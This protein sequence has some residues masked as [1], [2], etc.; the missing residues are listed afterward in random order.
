LRCP[1]CGND[2]PAT[3]RFCGM[4]GATLLQAEP[5]VKAE[6]PAVPARPFAVPSGQ[7]PPTPSAPAAI[8]PIATPSRAGAPFSEDVREPISSEVPAISGPS[9]LGLNDPPPAK[10]RRGSLS[11]DPGGAPGSRSLDYLLEDDDE[12]KSGGAWKFVLILIALAL[13]VGF[14]YLRW[15]NQAL[16]P[17]LGLSAHKP[18]ATPSSDATDSNSAAGTNAPSA[19][20]SSSA[21]ATSPTDAAGAPSA[22][23]TAPSSGSSSAASPSENPATTPAP[24]NSQSSAPSQPQGTNAAAAPAQANPTPANSTPAAGDAAD[25]GNASGTGAASNPA[26]AADTAQPDSAPAKP[27]PKPRPA[28]APVRVDQVAEARK[29]LYGQGAPQSCDRGLRLLKPLADQANPK[30][31]IE[32]GALYSAGLCTPRDLPTAYR[33]FALALRK[34][35]ANQPLQGDLQK[36]WGEMTQPE[37]QL[38]IK[39]SQ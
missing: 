16:P 29:Y 10:R 30:A 18:T 23:S 1:R 36:L 14:G 31:M 3:N 27:A 13:A 7:V 2:N 21:S 9:F 25:P 5:P 11:I 28:V 8:T 38:A 20:T 22:P 34:D 35:P 26:A 33:W 6:T 4:C 15:K 39:L 37:R 24:A 32:M 17:W 12:P 19:A